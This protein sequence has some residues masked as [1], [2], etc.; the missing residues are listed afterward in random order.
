MS[1]QLFTISDMKIGWQRTL[2]NVILVIDT[3]KCCLFPQ[4]K[5]AFQ[6]IVSIIASNDR[7]KTVKII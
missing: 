2:N 5:L 1:L 6:Y 4:S 7:I 3:G